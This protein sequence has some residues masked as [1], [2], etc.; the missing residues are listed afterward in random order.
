MVYQ[1][2]QI[3]FDFPSSYQTWCT[4]SLQE[5]EKYYNIK[6]IKRL[7]NTQQ[8]INN[9]PTKTGKQD[10]SILQHMHEQNS[11]PVLF[12]TK[13]DNDDTSN[14]ESGIKIVQQY[15]LYNFC[16]IKITSLNNKIPK[17]QLI[18]YDFNNEIIAT[19][20]LHRY[21][22]DFWYTNEET[23]VIFNTN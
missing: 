3:Y 19:E 4:T 10:E 11:I 22:A 23:F 14:D 8:H 13:I 18:L 20:R 21:W 12:K 15:S 17:Y 16:Y 9:N 7:N 6:N 5:R 1:K 2:N